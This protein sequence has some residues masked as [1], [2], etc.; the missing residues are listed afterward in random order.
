MRVKFIK[1]ES[2][3]YQ[4][5]VWNT[6]ILSK[7]ASK[8]RINASKMR[9]ECTKMRVKCIKIGVKWICI[10]L[11]H[12]RTVFKQCEGYRVWNCEKLLIS[13][14]EYNRIG[15]EFHTSENHWNLTMRNRQLGLTHDDQIIS[16]LS[17][18]TLPTSEKV[19]KQQ[20]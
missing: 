17:P 14:L 3:M 9:V 2:K 16:S 4:K 11:R 19:G 18:S 20:N 15:I 8:M 7:N 13:E 1:N 10:V 12:F 5:W 6:S